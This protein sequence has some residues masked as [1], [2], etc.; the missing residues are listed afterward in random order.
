MSLLSFTIEQLSRRNPVVSPSN[1]RNTVPRENGGRIPIPETVKESTT[2]HNI[3]G[4]S[5]VPHHFTRSET[6]F[7]SDPS[8]RPDGE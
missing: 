3:E 8:S 4:H 5:E 2:R 1:Y 6:T 7:C